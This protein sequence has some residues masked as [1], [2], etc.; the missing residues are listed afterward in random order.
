MLNSAC[1]PS[2]P[3]QFE[4]LVLEQEVYL[5]SIVQELT[6]FPCCWNFLWIVEY[7]WFFIS[8]SDRPGNC[9]AMFAHLLPWCSCKAIK[10]ASSSSDHSPF[11]KFGSRWLTYLSRHCL[12]CRPGRCA[13]IFAHFL[14]YL[15]LLSL[16]MLSSSIV[17][18]PFPFMTGG[19]DKDCHL[20]RQSKALLEGKLLAIS[21]HRGEA[22]DKIGQKM[23]TVSLETSILVANEWFGRHDEL[24]ILILLN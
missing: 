17:Q 18:E 22:V 21:F 14:P 9:F 15:S 24:T 1:S 10:M 11:F 23:K 16:N 12:P 19:L 3:M 4:Q 13:A 5:S 20:V 7:Q 8:L 2:F 6:S